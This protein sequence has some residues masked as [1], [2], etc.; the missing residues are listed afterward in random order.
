MQVTQT[1]AKTHLEKPSTLICRSLTSTAALLATLSHLFQTQL[2]HMSWP[3]GFSGSP[4]MQEISSAWAAAS[5]LP[6]LEDSGGKKKP[7]IQSF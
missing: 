4:S 7:S 5:C 1:A 6:D 3:S 2:G